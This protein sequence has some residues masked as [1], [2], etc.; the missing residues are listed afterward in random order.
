MG[1][2]ASQNRGQRRCKNLCGC[3][4]RADIVSWRKPKKGK[5]KKSWK[6]KIGRDNFGSVLLR[7]CNLHGENEEDCGFGRK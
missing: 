4:N 1:V 5:R 7:N 2:D 6:T 3:L